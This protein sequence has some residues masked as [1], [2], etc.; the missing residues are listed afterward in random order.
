MK[1]IEYVEY[2]NSREYHKGGY[3]QFAENKEKFGV[4]SD[5]DI[6]LYTTDVDKD[7]VPLY[8]LI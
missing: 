5:F 3:D 4:K 2:I 6:S 8:M 7:E 1:S